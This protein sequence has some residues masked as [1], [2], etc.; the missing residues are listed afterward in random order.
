[1]KSI[2][3]A[4][5]RGQITLPSKWRKNFSTDNFIIKEKEDI[6]EIRPVNIENL[7]KEEYTVFDALR[8]NK[9]KGIRAG[10][11]LKILNKIEKHG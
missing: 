7:E 3:K 9:G 11:L 1:M 8:D 2:V 6:L 5:S 4:T 10:E